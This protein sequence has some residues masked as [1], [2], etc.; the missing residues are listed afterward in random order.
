MLAAIRRHLSY[1][2][3]AAT[4]ALVLSMSGG[5]LAAS[6]YL[7]T[8]T[9]QLSPSVLHS[10]K[11]RQGRRGADGATGATGLTGLTGSRGITGPTGPR[12]EEGGGETGPT[13]P[14]GPAGLG[15]GG[16]GGGQSAVYFS[17]SIKAELKGT[18]KEPVGDIVPLFTL[19][20]VS[21]RLQC[22][23]LLV[24]I[25]EIEVTAPAGSEVELGT[26]A[27]TSSGAPSGEGSFEP[28]HAGPIENRNELISLLLQGTKEPFVNN[29][30]VSGSIITPSAVVPIDAFV[31]AQPNEPEEKGGGNGCTAMGTAF[32]VPR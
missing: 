5:A 31:R 25:A 7:I 32:S 2:N 11:G 24:T 16:G 4:L 23:S 18:A 13:G 15:G 30:H 12:A 3:V 22:M 10:L 20:E 14:T 29:A 26:T 21:V 1:A 9:K 8:S 19:P 17:R 6:H 28:V 27:T